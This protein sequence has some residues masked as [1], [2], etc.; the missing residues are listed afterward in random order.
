M[1]LFQGE[2]PAVEGCA[3]DAISDD[4][5]LASL[6]SLLQ[7][8]LSLDGAQ[9]SIYDACEVVTTSKKNWELGREYVN[10]V[11]DIGKG[12][13]CKVAKAEAWNINGIKGLTTVAV[14]MLKGKG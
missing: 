5:E 11:K 7:S 12:A 1:Y 9:Q 2:R 4:T 14:K 6:P 13:F 3:A 10:L 8:D